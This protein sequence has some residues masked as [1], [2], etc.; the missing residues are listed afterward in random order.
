LG[1]VISTRDRAELLGRCLDAV[2]VGEVLPA[3]IVV[4]DQSHNDRTRLVVQKHAMGPVEVRYVH[5][6]GSGLGA[7]QNLAFDLARRQVIAVLDDDCVASPRW[8]AVIEEAFASKEVD[9]LTGRVLPLG[10]AAPGVF[11]VATRTRDQRVDFSPDAMPWD[12]GSGN[13]FAASRAWLKRVGGNDERL[14][15]GALGQGAVDMDLFYRLLRAGARVRYEPESVV[16]HEQTTLSGR[17]ERRGPY[18]YGMGACCGIWIHRG[19]LHAARMLVGW[20]LMRTR[21]LL[22]GLRR[23]DRLTAR[24]EVLMLGGTLRGLAYGLRLRDPHEAA[25]A[26]ST[27]ITSVQ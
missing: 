10:P 2:M 25:A 3:E 15:P 24:E 5:H 4:V 23:G 7:S 17:L 27:Q 13:N 20:L 16:Y 14:G 26:S 1:V 22:A 21:R 18:G 12:I 6:A 9:V 11:A 19:D 8:A